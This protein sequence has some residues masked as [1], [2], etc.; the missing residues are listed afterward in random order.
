MNC[1][2][3]NR[4]LVVIKILF[5]CF[6][7]ANV[8]IL[9]AKV[10]VFAHYFGQPEFVK[11][12]H[13]FFSRNLIDEYEFFVFE[14]SNDPEIS[15][16]IQKKCKKYGV[17]YIHIPSSVFETPK[18][19]IND[20]YISLNAPSFQ[21]AVATQY[22]YDNYVILSQDICLILDNDIFLLSPFSIEKYLGGH[23]FSYVKEER[24]SSDHVVSYMLPNFI[25]LNPS[26][27]PE[28][29]RLDFNLGT[30]LEIHTDSGGFTYFYLLD[31]GFLGSEMPRY[32]L[33]KTSSDLKE[34]FGDQ[35]P[36]LFNSTEWLS[37]CFLEKDAFLHIRMGSNWSQH[38]QYPQMREEIALFFEK[39]LEN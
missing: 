2:Y 17:K 28:K 14:D 34:R 12:Q 30:I 29:E 19:P 37:H 32:Y 27:M 39:L 3:R 16:Q 13:L 22:I 10:N 18:L 8:S 38:P 15:E 20:W 11:Y 9:E 25:I 5:F 1:L 21:C 23:S 26:M 36:M 33:C 4:R 6:L 24:S 31:Y 35:C 7:C